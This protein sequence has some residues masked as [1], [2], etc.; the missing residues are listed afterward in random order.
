MITLAQRGRS[1]E[2]EQLRDRLLIHQLL[3]QRFG[4]STKRPRTLEI[5]PMHRQVPQIKDRS[6][7]SRFV[8][9]LLEQSHALF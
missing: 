7:D 8:L 6:C 9:E 1:Q 2:I 3:Q 4:F 5:S